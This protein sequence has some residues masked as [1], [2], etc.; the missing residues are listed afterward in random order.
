MQTIIIIHIFSSLRLLRK[1]KF[2]LPTQESQGIYYT[3]RINAPVEQLS[4]SIKNKNQNGEGS[5]P[6][7]K[8]IASK[9]WLSFFCLKVCNSG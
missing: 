6:S 9:L 3:G 8:K 7:I 5:G 4:S 1:A 2:L